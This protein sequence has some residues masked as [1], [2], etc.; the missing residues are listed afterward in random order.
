MRISGR[1]VS[2]RLLPFLGRIR[3][4]RYG[5][6]RAWTVTLARVPE[7][8]SVCRNP[9]LHFDLLGVYAGINT[10]VI[11]SRHQ[12]GLVANEV[13]V[14]DGPLIVEGHTRRTSSRRRRRGRRSP[15]RRS[16]QPDVRH[17]GSVH[18]SRG[19]SPVDAASA[20]TRVRRS[21]WGDGWAG[22]S[23]GPAGARDGGGRDPVRALA[24]LG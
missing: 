8:P 22:A 11:N 2:D 20:S 10:I 1:P 18:P 6:P 23:C 13:L 24:V 3:E 14:F 16:H 9:E 5:L 4:H 12:T 17:V 15:P 19:G 7:A 21:R